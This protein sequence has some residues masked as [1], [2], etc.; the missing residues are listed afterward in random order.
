MAM[1]IGT[2][3]ATVS[4]ECTAN[5]TPNVRNL[6]TR[7]LLS[8]SIFFNPFHPLNSPAVAVVTLY[9]QY[10][11]RFGRGRECV[12]EN[13][14]MKMQFELSEYTIS[15]ISKLKRKLLCVE[16]VCCGSGNK[17]TKIKCSFSWIPC[18]SLCAKQTDRWTDG[19]T[20][21]QTFWEN[22]VVRRWN[23]G[24]HLWFVKS[25]MN[26]CVP[27]S[28]HQLVRL[29]LD[30]L[31][32]R[33]FAYRN[34]LH[35]SD[36][37]NGRMCCILLCLTAS[38][39]YTNVVQIALEKRVQFCNDDDRGRSTRDELKRR[40]GRNCF[41][42]SFGDAKFQ[43]RRNCFVGVSSTHWQ[44][45]RFL[46]SLTF[47][48]TLLVARTR[49]VTSLHVH[50]SDASYMKN[51]IQ[52][53]LLLHRLISSASTLIKLIKITIVI[54]QHGWLS[55]LLFS[56]GMQYADDDDDPSGCNGVRH[57]Q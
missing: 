28:T 22:V 32:V 53:T 3:W 45:T 51:R 54:I 44:I 10:V 40:T 8:L 39:Q 7:N 37:M 17:R 13:W 52:Y 57:G 4:T 5:K 12:K 20:D 50:N 30:R 24:V 41:V 49:R 29:L 21:G 31:F 6:I 23:T 18:R 19:W 43:L 2:V 35:F 25:R 47:H 11:S 48:H 33:L 34:I 26:A 16:M 9:I 36:G 46:P 15:E 56:F 1:G 38:A 42:L 27:F 55:L 14:R